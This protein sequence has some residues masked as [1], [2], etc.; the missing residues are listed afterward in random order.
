[1]NFCPENFK[2]PFTAI[3]EKIRQR[4]LSEIFRLFEDLE[5]RD[6]RAK[7][8]EHVRHF[9]LPGHIDTLKL[10]DE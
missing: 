8:L 6:L 4:K 3:L 10:S 5:K 9:P 1:M 2:A 7:I